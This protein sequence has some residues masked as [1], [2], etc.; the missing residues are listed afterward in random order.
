LIFAANKYPTTGGAECVRSHRHPFE[1]T[2][3]TALR[4]AAIDVSAGIAF[5]PIGHDEFFRRRLL[6]SRPPFFL[7]ESLPR[8]GRTAPAADRGSWLREERP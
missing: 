6:A 8:R 3:R 7:S 1:Q 5:V 2:E 4:E